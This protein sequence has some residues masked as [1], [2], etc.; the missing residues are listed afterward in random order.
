MTKSIC[1]LVHKPASSR[2]AFQRYYEE[3][4]APLAVRF[5]P[6][7]GY[8]RNHL[9]DP[10]SFAWDTISEFWAHDISQA[11]ALMDGPVGETMRTDEARFMDQSRVA[12]AGAEETVL[13]S[14]EPADSQGR[15]TVLLVEHEDGERPSLEEYAFSIAAQY[16]GVRL[17]RVASW[18][19]PAFP[20]QSVIWIPGWVDVSPP[21]RFTSRVLKAR[22]VETPMEDLLGA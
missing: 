13:S 3:N 8:V 16:P 21:Q 9:V 20:A 2:E 12:P 10:G 22:R 11:A 15:R 18:A 1:A 4:H 17:D 6:F 5:F 14:G 19:E 7:S